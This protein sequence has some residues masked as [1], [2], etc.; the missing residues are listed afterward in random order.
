LLIKGSVQAGDGFSAGLLAGLG[1][2]TQYVTLGR[3]RARSV[4]RIGAAW[5][6]MAS[7]LAVTLMTVLGPSLA[8]LPPLTHFPRPSRA[9][10]SLGTL[11]LHTA[12]LFDLGIA[13]VVF[14][15]VVLIV[16]AI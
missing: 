14:G 1:A 12:L 8:G 16:D 5:P 9:V 15:A 7:G 4:V 11:K 3:E 13:C 6:I 2:I 10:V